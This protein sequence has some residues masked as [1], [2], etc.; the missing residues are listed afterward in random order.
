MACGQRLPV[1]IP[2]CLLTT[3]AARAVSPGSAAGCSSGRRPVILVA[4]QAGCP[5]IQWV[6]HI[7][8]NPR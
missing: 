6:P 3:T 2:V 4:S 7:R 8:A 1:G 5:R